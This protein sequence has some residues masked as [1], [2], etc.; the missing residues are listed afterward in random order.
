MLNA[1]EF[2]RVKLEVLLRTTSNVKWFYTKYEYKHYWEPFDDGRIT[3]LRKDIAAWHETE[4]KGITKI[5]LVSGN[6]EYVRLSYDD[7]TDIFKEFL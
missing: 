3:I 6:I 2:N 1:F 4:Y 5:V 7:V